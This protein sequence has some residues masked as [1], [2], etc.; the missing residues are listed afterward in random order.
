MTRKLFAI[1]PAVA[2]LVLVSETGICGPYLQTNLTS[3]LPGVAAHQDPH[4]VNPWGIASLAT[5]PFWISDNGAGVAT[6]YNGTG[7]PQPL[8]PQPLVVTVPPPLGGTPPSAPT[9]AVA[10]T[11]PDFG[12]SHFIFAA[13]GGTIAAWTS[14]TNAILQV[15]NSG[16]DAVYKGLAIGNNGSN[17]IYAANFRSGTRRVQWR[18]LAGYSCGRV[19]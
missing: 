9:G 16:A 5:S 13:E 7:T 3:D 18:L 11:T 14:G 10:N 2:V 17:L 4:L 15:D 1:V 6:L 12:G 8:V 19:Y